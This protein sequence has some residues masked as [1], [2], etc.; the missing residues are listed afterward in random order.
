MFTT[1]P[2]SGLNEKLTIKR[3]DF[4]PVVESSSMT[5][6][7]MNLGNI[8]DTYFAVS[9]TVLSA[10]WATASIWAISA[11]WATA[12]MW[13]ISGSEASHSISASYA[14]TA[15]S[16]I[17]SWHAWTASKLEGVG[18]SWENDLL[19]YNSLGITGSTGGGYFDITARPSTTSS[20]ITLPAIKL[21]SLF[22]NKEYALASTLDY[23]KLY[24][25]EDR[26][27]QAKMVFECGGYYVQ[28][29]QNG[30]NIDNYLSGA[31]GFL[32]QTNEAGNGS[33]LQRTA[34]L[35]FISSSGRVFS[36]AI[37]AQEF[38]SSLR[39]S[40][41]VG[42][43]GTASWAMNAITSAYAQTY[44]TPF[45]TGM[46]MGWAGA[47]PPAGWLDCDGTLLNVGLYPALAAQIGTN[48]GAS[49]N[50][51]QYI[52]PETDKPIYH[53]YNDGEVKLWWNSGGSGIYSLYWAF[54]AHTYYINNASVLDF[55]GLDAAYPGGTNYSYTWTDTGVTPN[56]GTTFTAH[57]PYSTGGGTSVLNV[58]GG[59]I[60]L[61]H[62]TS[63]YFVT[64]YV[65]SPLLWIIKT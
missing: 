29:K 35:M 55:T 43:V 22:L 17:E 5:T 52:K 48:Y 47:S 25:M 3:E 44:P 13:T 63:T 61:P 23:G 64:N 37:E 11:S 57:V 16:A 27:N 4:I 31:K 10:S 9:G 38:T 51:N 49:L 42:F 46:I 41:T 30:V 45:I 6:F 62:L 50:I 40:A 12:S 18:N 32:F 56:L 14:I 15:S 8:D 7:R 2:I 28:P 58:Y 21:N 24:F 19:I 59:G 54:T 39:S 1:I 33:N 26:R 20:F 53:S 34:S 65:I 60:R 36:R